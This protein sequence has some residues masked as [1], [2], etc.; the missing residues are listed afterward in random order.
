MR[1]FGLL[2]LLLVIVGCGRVDVP[3]DVDASSANCVGQT[4]SEH[5]T[6][7]LVGGVPECECQDGYQ[8]IDGSLA[9][10]SVDTCSSCGRDA[11]C[12]ETFGG[13]RCVCEEG[14]TGDGQK[15]TPDVFTIAVLGD[16]QGYV[17]DTKNVADQSR[18]QGFINQVEWILTNRADDN[19]KFVS[20]V[21][22]VVEHNTDTEWARSRLALDRMFTA[23]DL[24]W[25]VNLGNH[26]MAPGTINGA[27][28]LE[29]FGPQK[30]ANSPWYGGSDLGFRSSG[31]GHNSFQIVGPPSRQ[32]L[33]LNIEVNAD[34]QAISWAQNVI[35]AHLGMP[36]M[37]ST[38][39]FL[40]DQRSGSHP[41]S[42]SD[43]VSVIRSP[44]MKFIGKNSATRLWEKLI[45]PNNQIFLT[46]NGHYCCEREMVQNNDEGFPVLHVQVNYSVD[47]QGVIRADAGWIRLLEIDEASQEIRLRTAKPAVPL[48]NQALENPLPGSLVS[49]PM[50]W[51]G[52]FGERR[53][54]FQEGV[55]GYESAEDVWFSERVG[56][57]LPVVSEPFIRT[58]LFPEGTVNQQALLKFAGLVGARE[59]QIPVGATVISAS[60]HLVVP[61]DIMSSDG[62]ANAVHQML[63]DWSE[64]T[65]GFNSS[66][67]AGGLTGSID[68]DGTE[69]VSFSV[70]D[71][72]RFTDN[73]FLDANTDLL[74][75]GQG[76]HYDITAIAQDWVTNQRNFGVLFQSLG[77][78]EGNATFYAS[79]DYEG[80]AFGARPKLSVA[81]TETDN[82][83]FRYGQDGYFSGSDTW[84]SSMDSGTSEAT[85]TALH[86]I[87]ESRTEQI[88]IQFGQIVGSGEKQL[89]PGAIVHSARLVMYASQAL[90]SGST[91]VHALHRMRTSWA[92]TDTFISLGGNGI[93]F[94]DKEASAGAEATLLGATTDTG[95]INF[96]VTESVRSWIS[97]TENHGWV[98]QQLSGDD[99]LLLSSNEATEV[100]LRPRLVVQFTVE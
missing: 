58:A 89:P 51:R 84:L 66:P 43:T 8:P 75:Q 61:E 2:S 100:A 44:Q 24:A 59:N 16:T 77:T 49:Y 74:A 29:N 94:D 30:F 28:Y 27:K 52:R 53:L 38:H 55:N 87:S 37:L 25:S 6:C 9:C 40:N 45:A 63:V 80:A 71:T 21:G 60:L 3:V 86:C 50:T 76:V 39:E 12:A 95:T 31:L 70:A 67:W 96:D 36:T 98:L 99:R 56:E 81:Y 11:I 65:A 42:D 20:H 1:N 57:Q 14:F 79:S 48:Q 13:F 46:F 82:L 83:E 91:A 18:T 35:D 78:A 97:G 73:G 54:Q 62:E 88:L 22:D 92:D 19:I 90:Y 5:G 15:C 64:P 7:V 32:Y 4:C 69:A 47:F 85:R 33:H 41:Q 10:E 17:D 93:Q 23:T 34:D 68:R 26:D 72:K